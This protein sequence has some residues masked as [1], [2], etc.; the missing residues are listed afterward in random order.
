MPIIPQAHLPSE[1]CIFCET[2]RANRKA[3]ALGK[4]SSRCALGTSVQLPELGIGGL[5]G[6]KEVTRVPADGATSKQVSLWMPDVL[7]LKKEQTGSQQNDGRGH[8]TIFKG[9]C[10]RP[11][12]K[13]DMQ[14]ADT[15]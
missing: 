12:Q 6:A 10:Y 8:A 14:T 15:T 4:G 7:T 5:A 9:A 1:T 13:G 11:A 2:V 3:T